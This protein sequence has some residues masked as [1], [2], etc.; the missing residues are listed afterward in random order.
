[1][2]PLATSTVNGTSTTTVTFNNIPQTFTHLQLRCFVRSNA[3]ANYGTSDTLGLY[4]N[5]DGSTTYAN[6][7]LAGGDGS[8]GGTV[9]S[10]ANNSAYYAICGWMA[11]SSS[12]TNVFSGHIID[13]LDYT[14]T[15]KLKTIKQLTGYED[16]RSGFGYGESRLASSL[17]RTNTNAIT[18]LDMFI[19]SGAAFAP[20]TTFQLY[21]IQTS[22]ATGA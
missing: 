15:N 1:M 2:F 10:G 6:H 17:Y 9:F 18:R 12:N 22:N 11:T 13:I 4:L 16:N 21:G 14:N 3:A 7:E 8:S 19:A 20:S 5:A